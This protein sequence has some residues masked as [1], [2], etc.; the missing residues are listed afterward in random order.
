MAA[1]RLTFVVMFM[2]QV[3]AAL[4]V[5]TLILLLGG[6]SGGGSS[7]LG[8]VLALLA[9]L[10]CLLGV[11]LP[12]AL[13]R[14]GDKGSVLSATLLSAVLLATPVWFLMLALVTGQRPLP[15]FLLLSAALAGYSLGF[16]LCGR[17]GSRA[18][19]TAARTAETADRTAETE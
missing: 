14:S 1:L 12:D 9:F 4:L 11:L 19:A 5:I 15:L 3:A 16:W 7:V 8:P 10:Q 18:A 6:S 2:A 13:A 17:L